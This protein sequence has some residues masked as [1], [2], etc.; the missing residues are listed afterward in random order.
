M[1]AA[2]RTVLVNRNAPCETEWR[3]TLHQALRDAGLRIEHLPGQG[4]RDAVRD[5]QPRV[6]VNLIGGPDPSAVELSLLTPVAFPPNIVSATF[7]GHGW[8]CQRDV[9]IVLDGTL[10][11]DELG[12]LICSKLGVPPPLEHAFRPFGTIRLG[13]TPETPTTPA[14]PAPFDV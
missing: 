4:L 7:S 11:P 3:V 5:G 2:S 9:R 8:E 13:V 6:M 12:D 14:N 10:T 1:N